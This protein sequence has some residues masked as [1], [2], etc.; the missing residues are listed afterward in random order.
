MQTKALALMAL[1]GQIERPDHVIFSDTG[2]E[3]AATYSDLA[4]MDA[5]FALAGVSFER[6]G[7][8][9]LRSDTLDRAETGRTSKRMA[10]MPFYV[11]LDGKKSM[12]KRQCTSEYKIEPIRSALWRIAGRRS[13]PGKI[14]MWKGISRDEV[15]RMRDSDVAYIR[16]RYPLVE[17]RDQSPDEFA[18]AV[19][20][21]SR[22]RKIPGID[23][24]LFLHRRCIPLAEA[25][26]TPADDGQLSMLSNTYGDD[27][28]FETFES[29]CGSECG[30]D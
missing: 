5:R 24:E 28:D 20:F 29:M 16:N 10:S 25:V 13:S 2:W 11:L 22:I 30:V 14:E 7:K 8:G 21:D 17:I 3:R 9:N 27:A 6:V 26:H 23:G 15:H 4:E 19:E 18:D 12:I 1:D